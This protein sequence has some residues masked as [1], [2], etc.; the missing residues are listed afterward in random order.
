MNIRSLLP[1]LIFLVLCRPSASQSFS[2]SNLPIVIINTD[3]GI[4]I[5]D[6]PRIPATMKI[7]YR[8]E[9]MRNYLSDQDNPEYLNYNGR[10][11]IELRGSS[12][13]AMEKKQYGFSTK[14]PDGLTKNNV[15]LSVRSLHDKKL[16]EF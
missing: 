15:S 14:L 12:S 11:S 5:P 3:G 10:I 8:G 9:S 13:Q 16:S 7:I 1:F 2:D 4:E 6:D